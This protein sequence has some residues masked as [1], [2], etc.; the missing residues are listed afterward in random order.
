[1]AT[2]TIEVTSNG[3]NA[4]PTAVGDTVSVAVGQ[5]VIIDVA[6]NDTDDTGLNLASIIS[7][8]SSLGGTLENVNIIVR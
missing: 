3:S 5:P 4:A 8:E 6:A 2:V 1:M 7:I